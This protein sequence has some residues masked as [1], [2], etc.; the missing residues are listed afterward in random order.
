MPRWLLTWDRQ[1][2]AT[3][4]DWSGQFICYHIGSQI[5]KVGFD[6]NDRGFLEG[7]FTF[8]FMKLKINLQSKTHIYNYAYLFPFCLVPEKEP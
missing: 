3:E 8:C 6:N 4:F 1:I 2:L 5:L 7:N